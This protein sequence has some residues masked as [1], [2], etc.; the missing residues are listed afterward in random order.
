MSRS[1][2]LLMPI[3][4]LPTRRIVLRLGSKS[5]ILSRQHVKLS[6]FRMSRTRNLRRVKFSSLIGV[7]TLMS[8]MKK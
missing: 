2:K 3:L 4:F 8:M 1:M 5:P 6:V 7:L